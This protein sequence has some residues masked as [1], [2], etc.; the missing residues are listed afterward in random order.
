MNKKDLKKL[1]LLGL[2]CGAT[3]AAQSSANAAE[4]VTLAGGCGGM[5]SP[6]SY[7]QSSEN[8]A[9]SHGCSGQAAP[10][11]YYAPAPVSSGCASQSAPRYTNTP[12][13]SCSAYAPQATQGQYNGQRPAGEYTQ[14]DR[15]NGGSFYNQQ[16]GTRMQESR[17]FNSQNQQWGQSEPNAGSSKNFPSS[18]SPAQSNNPINNQNLQNPIIK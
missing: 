12:S 2:T 3:L 17:N 9:P 10:G 14:G 1:C 11:G 4:G 18:M 13:H 6:R 8:Y 16:E 15:N 5:S 7:S